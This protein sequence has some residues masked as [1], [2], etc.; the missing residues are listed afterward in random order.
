MRDSVMKHEWY[1]KRREDAGVI[2]PAE[3]IH[4]E[5]AACDHRPG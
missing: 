3:C 5:V 1:A 4:L 2:A